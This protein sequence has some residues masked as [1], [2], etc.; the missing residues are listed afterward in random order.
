ME[1]LRAGDADAAYAFAAPGIKT[2]F[3]TSAAFLAMLKADY[4]PVLSSRRLSFG[5]VIPHGRQVV[6]VVTLYSAVGIATRALYVMEPQGDGSWQIAGCRLVAPD[7][8][9]DA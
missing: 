5:P 9:E 2:R 8:E 6:Q 4:Q 1:A 7:G 3:P